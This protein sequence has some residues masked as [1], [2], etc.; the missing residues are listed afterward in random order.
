MNSRISHIRL[1]EKKYH[2]Y[3]YDNYKIFEQGSWLYKPVDT[4]MNCLTS[5]SNENIKV[6]DLGCGVGRN[7]IPIAQKISGNN[8][9]VVCVDFLEAATEKLQKY[10]KE[11]GVEH[12]IEPITE[13]IAFFDIEEEGYDYIVAVSSLEHVKSKDELKKVLTKME[14]GTK[15]NGINC[16]I[17]NS[18]VEEVEIETG[19]TMDAMMEINLSTEEMLHILNENYNEWS[20]ITVLTKP[21]SYHINRGEKSVLLT[22]NAITFVVQKQ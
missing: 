7:S 19:E 13:D 2:E 14:N 16:I 21:L 4:V 22:T 3:C 8:S 20:K 9:K 5:V 10:S 18:E 1:E 12:I 15:M 11:Y 6:L 17:V